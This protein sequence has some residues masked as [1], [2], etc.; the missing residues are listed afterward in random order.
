MKGIS[1]LLYATIINTMFQTANGIFERTSFFRLYFG[2]NSLKDLLLK[3]V[4]IIKMYLL[5]CK[6]CLEV[7]FVVLDLSESKNSP[8]LVQKD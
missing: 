3:L 6:R 2:T 4:S 5:T 8:F 1:L 7:F